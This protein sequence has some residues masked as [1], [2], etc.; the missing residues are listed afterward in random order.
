MFFSRIKLCKHLIQPN[1]QMHVL[2]GNNVFEHIV[3]ILTCV[4]GDY[5][6]LNC[7]NRLDDF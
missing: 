7:H 1:S 5:L 3:I 2:K 6:T 4:K